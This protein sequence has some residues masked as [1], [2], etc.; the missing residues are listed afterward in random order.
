MAP[1][2][3]ECEVVPPIVQNTSLNASPEYDSL[4]PPRTSATNRTQSS[5]A[6]TVG[7][8]DTSTHAWSTPPV[9]TLPPWVRS[10]D[11]PEDESD[12][13]SRLLPTEI[14][15]AQVA[16]HN[17]SPYQ[18]SK[19][20]RNR[21]KGTDDELDNTTLQRE[22]R[23]KRFAQTAT[24][25]RTEVGAGEKRVSFDWLNNN[26]GD[27]SQPWGASHDGSDAELGRATWSPRQRNLVELWIFSLCAL[28]LGGSIRALAYHLN[29]D[30]GPSADMAIVVDAVALVYLVYITY[31]EYASKPLGLRSPK[32][33]MRLILLDLFFIVFDAANL[34]LAFVS[35]DDVQGTCTNAVINDIEDDRNDALCVRQKALASVLLVALIAWLLTFCISIFRL[36]ERVSK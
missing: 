26:L 11:V 36:V 6:V 20:D 9:R 14:D 29:R 34:S 12:A 33:K 19:P 4:I 1:D 32:A 7:S 35:L 31:D 21:L 24:Y 23:W 8:H 22:S 10:Y 27:Y 3:R 28:A 5:F 30:Q 2:A 13:S 18:A 25:P 15:D 17:H 16:Q